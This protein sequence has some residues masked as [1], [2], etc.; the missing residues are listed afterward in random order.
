MDTI[1][2]WIEL[3]RSVQLEVPH[4]TSLIPSSPIPTKD[5]RDALLRVGQYVADHGFD[6][7]GQYR[8]AR[9]LLCLRPPTIEGV[10]SGSPLVQSG[11]RAKDAALRLAPSLADSYLAIQGPP[12][13]GKTTVGAEMILDLV[14]RGKRVGITANSHK[15]IGN[16][17]DKLMERARERAQPVRAIQK[18]DERE[19]CASQEVQCTNSAST[20]EAALSGGELDV[21][22]GTP[23]LFAR[24]SFPAKLDY[25]VVDEAGQMALANVLAIAGVANNLILLGDPNQLRQPSHG[26][27][28]E[29]V[30]RSVL[31]H[32]IQDH[33]TMPGESGLFLE[34]TYRLHP[35]VCSFVSEVFYDG[36]LEPDESTRRQELGFSN[37][38]GGLGLRYLPVEHAGNRT[39]SP[40]EA[41]RVDQVLRSLLGLP[42]TSRDGATRPLVLDDVLVVA[43]YNAQ[44][45]R[46]IETLSEG[47]R[48]GTVDKF[49]GQEAPIVI[50]SM[51]TSS[52]DD[53]PRGMDFLFSLNRLNVAASRAQGL[54]ILVCSPELLKA[55]CQT[56]QQMRLASALC[57]LVEVATSGDRWL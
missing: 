13:S 33:P 10:T 38:T 5:Q 3:S 51:A 37:G 54:V 55:R 32:V 35:A 53:A 26:I 36:K 19:R 6:G 41:D 23:W 30:D 12:G 25:L 9:D 1:A 29:G 52:V 31:D 49:Q 15:V 50:Y 40:E 16:L 39:V 42:W 11:E 34:T 46:L 7:I 48:V 18:A 2:G 8:A 27:H 56:P 20:V 14:K 17:L 45:R 57:R 28:P 43:P 44:V 47:A 21:V 22:A 4:P 24:P